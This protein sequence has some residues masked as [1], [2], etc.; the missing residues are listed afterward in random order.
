MLGPRAGASFKPTLLAGNKG[1]IV[2]REGDVA[3]G[4]V[5]VV[6]AGVPVADMFEGMVVFVAGMLATG[7][8]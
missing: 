5:A 3:A 6:E 4:A 1:N 8:L 2:P 7:A